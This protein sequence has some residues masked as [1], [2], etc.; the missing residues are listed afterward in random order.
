[1]RRVVPLVA[2]LVLAGPV[3]AAPVRAECTRVQ[4]HVVPARAGVT[5]PD[6]TIR[7]ILPVDYCLRRDR[8]EY[9]VVYLLH[10]AGDT[11]QTWTAN[12]DVEEFSQAHGVII[13]TPDGGKNVEAGWYSD[14]IDESRDWEVFHTDMLVE[15]VDATFRTLGDGHRAIAGLSMGGFGAMSYAARWDDRY[16]AAAEFSGAVD[17]MIAAPVSGVVFEAL[18]PFVGTPREDVWGNQ[19][20]DEEV[21]R[22]HNP[23]DLVTELDDVEL[24]LTWGD[25]MPQSPGQ[26]DFIELG[27]NQMH[28]TFR[29]ALDGVGIDREERFVPGGRHAWPD[30]EAALH[31]A[32]PQLVAAID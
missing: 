8:T 22:A 19:V 1:M 9:P 31:W 18:N 32:L 20:V 12:T 2:A 29:D 26:P 30:W 3:A 13:V 15:Y 10:G 24:F 28:E 6:R 11:W 5:V 17:T 14:W 7:V 27:I 4:D 25:G 23:T 21:W 16:A